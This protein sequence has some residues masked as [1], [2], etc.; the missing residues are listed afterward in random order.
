MFKTNKMFNMRNTIV[1]IALFCLYNCNAFNNKLSSL[2]NRKL[3]SVN[4]YQISCKKEDGKCICQEIVLHLIILQKSVMQ[5][6][7]GNGIQ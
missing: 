6:I 1:V 2:R 7:V 4:T 5:L 3:N